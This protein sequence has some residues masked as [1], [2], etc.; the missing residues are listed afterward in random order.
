MPEEIRNTALAYSGLEEAG[1]RAALSAL[2]LTDAE[3]ESGT[4]AIMAQASTLGLSGAFSAL[5]AKIKAAATGLWT[6]LT[7][8][9]VGWAILAATAIF[10]LAKAFDYVNKA[11]DRAVERAKEARDAYADAMSTVDSLK[12]RLEDLNDQIAEINSQETLT[13]TDREQL[14]LLESER[15]ELERELEIRQAIAQLKGAESA[16]EAQKALSTNKIKRDEFWD[17]Y[18]TASGGKQANFDVISGS[19]DVYEKAEKQIERLNSLKERRAQFLAEHAGSTS[20]FITKDLDE[21]DEAI[22]KQE[23]A[24]SST[25]ETLQDNRTSFIIDGTNQIIDGYE[26]NVKRI[27]TILDD[28]VKATRATY[29]PV[30]QSAQTTPPAAMSKATRDAYEK[31]PKEVDGSVASEKPTLQRPEA[32]AAQRVADWQAYQDALAAENAALSFS[33]NID[34]ESSGIEAVQSAMKASTEAAG[35][36]SEA[37]AKLTERYQEI[38]GFNADALFERTANGFRVNSDEAARLE[39]QLQQ[40]NQDGIDNKMQVL[41]E[42]LDDVNSQLANTENLSTDE[43]N[44]L[45]ITRGE[46]AAKITDLQNEATAYAALTSNYNQWLNAQSAGEAGDMY[47][48]IV[49]GYENAKALFDKGL[50]GTNEFREYVELV[51]GKD[52]SAAPIKEIVD[53][54]ERLHQVSDT[55][56]FAPLDY[57]SEGSAGVENFISAVQNAHAEWVTFDEATGTWTLDIES[58]DQLAEELDVDSE[59][60][61]SLLGKVGDYG[62]T[63]NKQLEDS[64]GNA[65]QNIDDA[66]SNL[67]SQL[68]SRGIKIDLDTTDIDVATTQMFDFYDYYKTLLDKNGKINLDSGEAQAAYTVMSSLWDLWTELSSQNSVV[69]NIDSS[70]ITAASSAADQFVGGLDVVIEKKQELAKKQAL[71]LDTTDADTDLNNAISKLNTLYGA[72]SEPDKNK[73]KLEIDDTG[74][75]K[76]NID[77]IINSLDA[78]PECLVDL[79]VSTG[80][81]PADMTPEGDTKEINLKIGKNAVQEWIDKKGKSTD[82]SI[83]PLLDAFNTWLNLRPTKHVNVI[84]HITDVN[85]FQGNAHAKGVWGAKKDETALTGELG[86]ELVVD[87]KT[88]RWHT[89]GDRGAEFAHIPQGAIVFNHKQTEQLFKYG[90]I[91]SRG[92]AVASGNAYIEGFNHLSA[93]ARGETVLGHKPGAQVAK[94]VTKAANDVVSTT[95]K[96]SHAA[97]SSASD[98]SKAASESEESIDSFK[99]ENSKL[100]DWVEKKLEAI[101]KKATKY[102]DKAE[103][104]AEHGNYSGAERQY[105]KAEATYAKEL[106]KQ[107]DAEN[108]YMSQANKILQSAIS[109]GLISASQSEAIQKRVANGSMDISKVSDSTKEVI[110][111]YEEYYK[112]AEEAAEATTELYDKYEEVAN[113]IYQLPLDEAANKIDELDKEFDLLEKRLET[114]HDESKKVKLLEEQIANV[115]KKHAEQLKAYKK[116]HENYIESQRKLNESTDKALKGLSENVV[117][118]ITEMV[119]A[120][121]SIDLT[122]MI[123]LTDEAKRAILDYNEALAAQSQALYDASM[124]ALDTLQKVRE[125]SEEIANQPNEEA[126]ANIDKR[127]ENDDT[128]DAQYEAADTAHDKNVILRQYDRQAGA[129]Y[130]DAF[131]AYAD[132]VTNVWN[133]W[134]SDEIARIRDTNINRGITE[135]QHLHWNGVLEE[136]DIDPKSEDAAKLRKAVVEYND[137]VDALNTA[138]D[139]FDKATAQL[140]T[141]R[142]DNAIKRIQNVTDEWQAKIDATQAEIDRVNKG[143]EAL[144]DTMNR[145]KSMSPE[146]AKAEAQRFE[147]AYG[148]SIDPNATYAENRVAGETKKAELYD[149]QS[150]QYAQME[151]NVGNQIRLELE[152]GLI[153]VQEGEDLEQQI[154]AYRQAGLEAEQAMADA[155]NEAAKALSEVSDEQ[156]TLNAANEAYTDAQ[157]NIDVKDS[158]GKVVTAQDYQAVIDSLEGTTDENGVHIPGVI[159]LETQ[160]NLQ[161]REQLEGLVEG[162]DEF[163]ELQDAIQASDDKLIN[164]NNSL[165][166]TKQALTDLK[167][168]KFDDELRDIAHN[169]TML[170]AKETAAAAVGDMVG[171]V[172]GGGGGGSGVDY[173]DAAVSLMHMI[174][175]G[176]AIGKGIAE[177]IND[178]NGF[179]ISSV[180]SSASDSFD[181]YYKT[182]THEGILQD[183]HSTLEA[184]GAEIDEWFKQ[185]GNDETNADYQ[186]MVAEKQANEEAIAQNEAEQAQRAADAAEKASNA[187]GGGGGL[188]DSLDELKKLITDLIH[189]HTNIMKRRLADIEHKLSNISREMEITETMGLETTPDQ[190]VEKIDAT[191]EEISFYENTYIPQL[192]KE[193][194]YTE[195]ED[196][197]ESQAERTQDYLAYLEAVNT[198]EDL[199]VE[200][201]KLERIELRDKILEPLK[202]AHEEAERMVDILATIDGLITDDM[203]FDAN[204]EL[205]RNGQQRLTLL[206]GQYQAAEAEVQNYLNEIEALERSRINGEYSDLEFEELLGE[207]QKG[208]FEAERDRVDLAEQY[209]DVLQQVGQ[210]ELDQLNELIDARQEALQAKKDYYDYDKNIRRKTKDIQSLEAQIAALEGLTD[211]ESKAKRAKLEADLSDAKDE[212]EDMVQ[213]H[214]FDFDS[215]ALDKLRETLEDAFEDQWKAITSDLKTLVDYVGEISS[216]VSSSTI[217]DTVKDIAAQVGIDAVDIN[218]TPTDAANLSGVF[219]E[220][221]KDTLDNRYSKSILDTW[222]ETAKQFFDIMVSKGLWHGTWI[223]PSSAE[224]AAYESANKI[225]NDSPIGGK[226]PMTNWDRIKKA[227]RE[228]GPI[229]G[230]IF[231]FPANLIGSFWGGADGGEPSEKVDSWLGGFADFLELPIWNFSKAVDSWKHQFDDAYNNGYNPAGAAINASQETSDQ[232]AE[233]GNDIKTGWDKLVNGL[234]NVFGSH[235]A[236]AK[237]IKHNEM[238]W[239]QE[240]GKEEWIVRKSDGAIL[241]P[242]SKGDGVLPPD[243]TSKLYS[244]AQGNLPQMQMPTLNLPDYN[245]VE[246]F[247]PTYNIDCSINVNGS[248]DATVVSDMKK[249][250]D[251]VKDDMYQYISD[252]MYRGYIHSGGKRRL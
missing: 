112:K 214:V 174:G 86:P 4:A 44:A 126:A 116:A 88:G 5:G 145:M 78:R 110:E 204:D 54:W 82:V 224:E 98:V 117:K 38:S 81:L 211:A 195:S 41:S 167:L 151:E 53:E 103:K 153:S 209:L 129:D 239:T 65:V 232:W 63:V 200:L 206:I 115:E 160:Q 30:I 109:K 197:D 186:K 252:K 165:T 146:D 9:P 100:Y 183:Q 39:S 207:A 217:A 93:E 85:E 180:F 243:I 52:L 105:R 191:R 87:T 222:E 2:D 33:I 136:L 156:K 51:S 8:N 178:P 143:L 104:K 101:D 133:S 79:K 147:D 154:L 48:N 188:S 144:G 179:S 236:G 210:K 91:N 215:K 1:V 22:A 76:E 13:I 80:I 238:A 152:R 92:H 172:L 225:D 199:K 247:S 107:R 189:R 69:Y 57:L 248:V 169:E 140:K 203:L 10:G 185:P 111:A 242:L 113:K 227:I 218:G 246:E 32:A 15:Q 49:K 21:F 75:S 220:S 177:A 182:Q 46:I 213:D 20:E 245:V 175:G 14:S 94:A 73:L 74:I 119:K 198:M 120:G 37:M 131:D 59:L 114:T 148:F 233:I 201:L 61:E 67:Q 28:A 12:S 60:V 164:L 127:H 45:I 43:V 226:L 106:S 135:G 168:G 35:I 223:S 102:L 7:T 27:D 230:T 68:E 194:R 70:S 138:K 47:D 11:Q 231:G 128:L 187:L 216:N 58:V 139:N 64:F 141:T 196:D 132:A 42:Q 157:R 159:E 193:Y 84:Q 118:S 56:G 55:T 158:K 221:L 184:K 142:H 228:M 241:T 26:E 155:L 250:R 83:H 208:L 229:L 31:A 234:K 29:E 19:Y 202:K 137:Y 122:E 90:K 176:V 190:I 235:A 181:E 6:F 71:G 24:L 23:Q 237:R 50:T 170:D 66:M 162:T 161:M 95:R 125:L 36:N 108:I 205:T 96:A 3:I 124:S 150:T 18:P 240:H 72:L 16:R 134:T 123:G 25:I 77:A 99:D 17:V 149:Q 40:I 219:E 166:Q 173:G 192:E 121:E 89:V 251:E 244:L 163:N 212:L 62:H 34:A 130:N 97:T 171:A 249:F